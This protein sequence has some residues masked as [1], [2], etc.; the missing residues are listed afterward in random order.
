[1]ETKVNKYVKLIEDYGDMEI[2]TVGFCTA[3][4]PDYEDDEDIFAVQFEDTWV[5]FKDKNMRNKW[6]VLP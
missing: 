2:G 3:D 5:T 6:K 4:L 1:M